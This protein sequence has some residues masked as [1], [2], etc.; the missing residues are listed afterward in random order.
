LTATSFDLVADLLQKLIS[1][2]AFLVGGV[3]VLLNYVRNRTH[4]PR[5]QVEV[6]AKIASVATGIIWWLPAR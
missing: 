1:S 6:K 4:Y 2:F 5:L 3:W